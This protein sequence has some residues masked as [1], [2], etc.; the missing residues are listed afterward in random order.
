MLEIKLF[1][2]KIF[3]ML[4]VLTR[5][6]KFGKKLSVS[7]NKIL[8]DVTG[9]LIFETCCSIH[10]WPIVLLLHEIS[11]IYKSAVQFHLN[12]YSCADIGQMRTWSCLCSA[13]TFEINE[14]ESK[15]SELQDMAVKYY[16]ELT[17]L[18]VYGGHGENLVAKIWKTWLWKLE[19]L[20]Y[21]SAE[22]F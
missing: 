19:W 21:F 14:D 4:S 3:P 2:A 6:Q 16:Y 9:R 17:S 13:G 7:K 1:G 11:L 15:I 12:Q 18:I 20:K 22:H 5:A 10:W 8:D